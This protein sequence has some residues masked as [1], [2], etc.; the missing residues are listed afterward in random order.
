MQDLN[1]VQLMLVVALLAGSCFVPSLWKN[2]PEGRKPR[3]P[4]EGIFHR[5]LATLGR[6]LILAAAW[7]YE[8]VG[9]FS[10]W[11]AHWPAALSW[12]F[13]RSLSFK[14]DRFVQSLVCLLLADW[15]AWFIAREYLQAR[16]ERGASEDG[17]R[18]SHRPPAT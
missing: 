7:W 18:R 13:S 4:Q 8:H 16:L 6:S 15:L 11:L 5:L 17:R 1:H 12:R 10:V 14:V 3:Q 9:S 2:P